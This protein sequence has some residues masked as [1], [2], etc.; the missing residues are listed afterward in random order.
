MPI[1]FNQVTVCEVAMRGLMD[2]GGSNSIPTNFLFHFRRTAVTVDPTKTAINTAFLA[3]PAAAIAAALNQRWNSTLNDIRYPN[4]ATDPYQSFT[5]ALSGAITGDS[6]V[7][8]DAAYLLFR[9][10]LRGR[11]F[12]GSKHLGPMSESDRTT[13]AEDLWNAACLTRLAAIN[14]AL[15]AGF[16]D[17]T[18]NIWKFC[19]LSRSLSQLSVNPTIVTVNDVTQGLVNKRTGSML[20]RKVASVY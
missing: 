15:L 7:S 4:D 8:D 20:R 10:A 14:T 17:S 13:A 19:I 16:T 6:L 3:G 5:T 1:P 18:G 2:A 11:Q 9:T 12:R